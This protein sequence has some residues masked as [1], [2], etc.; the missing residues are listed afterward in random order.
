MALFGVEPR[1]ED[2]QLLRAGDVA[3]GPQREGAGS[4]EPRL[5]RG[6]EDGGAE[7]AFRVEEVTL[8]GEVR[9]D[10]VELVEG[11]MDVV[12]AEAPPVDVEGFLPPARARAVPYRAK[13]GAPGLPD[14]PPPCPRSSCRDRGGARTGVHGRR[15][16]RRD[17]SAPGARRRTPARWGG[18]RWCLRRR[19]PG[20]S[21]PCGGGRGACSRRRRRALRWSRSRRRSRG[22]GGGPD[23]IRGGRAIEEPDHARDSFAPARRRTSGRSPRSRAARACLPGSVPPE[24]CTPLRLRMSPPR[25][26]ARKVPSRVRVRGWPSCSLETARSSS[27]APC[28]PR[29]RSRAV[30]ASPSSRRDR[31]D[32]ASC[33]RT[34]AK[35]GPGTEGGWSP[36]R[37]RPC[38]PRDT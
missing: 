21:E 27:S 35:R 4:E 22:A 32:R 7:G 3:E 37:A 14:C 13:T 17:W 11:E 23:Q 6:G 29:L 28:T 15:G 10:G 24:R 36:H 33:P 38:G 18:R 19:P 31:C 1:G 30:P 5:V 34:P 9:G 16:S 2:E 20:A 12:A 8:R 26:S 25:A